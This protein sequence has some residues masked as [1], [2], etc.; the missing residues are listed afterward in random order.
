[1]FPI[2]LAYVSAKSHSRSLLQGHPRFRVT[3]LTQISTIFF[4]KL[5]IRLQLFQCHDQLFRLED[6]LDVDRRIPQLTVLDLSRRVDLSVEHSLHSQTQSSALVQVHWMQADLE[7]EGSISHEKWQLQGEKRHC[8]SLIQIEWHACFGDTCVHKLQI[9][10]A[11][12]SE[13]GREPGHFQTESLPRTGVNDIT[14]WESQKVPNKCQAQANE[15]ASYAA[16][17]RLGYWCFCGPGLDKTWKYNEERPSHHDLARLLVNELLMS[18]HPVSK[19]SNILVTSVLMRRKKGE[20]ATTHFKN[21]PENHRTLVNMM[22]ACHQLCL[23]FFAVSNWVRK[24]QYSLRL[25][26]SN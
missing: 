24:N 19:C 23:C 17:V 15:V 11:F 6:E 7:K 8:R 25:P 18:K 13:T 20:G 9:L 1:M 3:S 2:R 14:N 10:K 4:V 22:L 5:Q 26:S 21:E 16:R 12:M